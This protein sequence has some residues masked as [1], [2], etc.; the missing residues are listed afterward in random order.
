VTLIHPKHDGIEAMMSPQAGK[1]RRRLLIIGIVGP[2][3]WQAP[4]SP[5][6]SSTGPRSQQELQPVDETRR[7]IPDRRAP[8]A[9]I[10]HSDA[11][12]SLITAR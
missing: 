3:G 1:T 4:S 5:T 6:A 10:T 9:Q 7:A 12:Q 2:R 8:F 11:G